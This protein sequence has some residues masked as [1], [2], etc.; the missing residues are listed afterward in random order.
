M[1]GV[2]SDEESYYRSM[3]FLNSSWHA[4]LTREQNSTDK[5]PKC[6]LL[7]VI[8]PVLKTVGF[9][10]CSYYSLTMLTAIKKNDHLGFC[11]KNTLGFLSWLQTLAGW[12]EWMYPLQSS[13]CIGMLIIRGHGLYRWN[14]LHTKFSRRHRHTQNVTFILHFWMDSTP[15]YSK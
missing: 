3:S 15:L 10:L 8:P 2:H 4:L 9:C 11:I 14:L 1:K 6:A 7:L 12:N 5:P 13:N